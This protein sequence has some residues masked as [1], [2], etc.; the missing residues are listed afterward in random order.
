MAARA[1]GVI[2]VGRGV[3]RIACVVRAMDT[4]AE[5]VGSGQ[6]GGRAAYHQRRHPRDASRAV[7]RLHIPIIKPALPC[8]R[9]RPLGCSNCALLY[10]FTLPLPGHMAR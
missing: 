4:A 1:G 2:I 10:T 7:I 8:A 3:I 9:P 6:A 5:G